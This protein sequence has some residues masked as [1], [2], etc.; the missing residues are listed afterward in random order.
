MVSF[1]VKIP[2]LPESVA[3]ATVIEWH[4]NLGDPVAAGENLV[5]IETDKVVLEVPAPVDGYLQRILVEP[6]TVVG[7]GDVVG[8]LHDQA[9][10][11]TEP[12]TTDPEQTT[13]ALAASAERAETSPTAPMQQPSNRAITPSARRLIKN[14]ALDPNRIPSQ[15]KARRLVKDDV[16]AYLAEHGQAVTAAQT[17]QETAPIDAANHHE[18]T[19]TPPTAATSPSDTK[20][21]ERRVPIT[22]LRARVAERLLAVTQQ[23]AMLTTFND[24]DMSSVIRLRQTHRERFEQRHGVRLGIMSFFAKATATALKRFPILNAALEEDHIVYHDFYDIGIAVSSSRGLVVPVVRHVDQLS[25]AEIEQQICDFAQ[26]AEAGQLSIDELAQGTFTITNG[27]V[28]GSL[29]STPII[30]P[31][32]TAILGMHRIEDRP[33]AVNGEV[34]IRPMMYLAL[35]YDHRLVDGRDAVRFLVDIKALIEEPARLLLDI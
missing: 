8:L 27:G 34:A 5:D 9:E 12:A 26:R 19:P 31:P 3:E 23:T 32:Q 4:K 30:N 6:G 11:A 25:M 28:F 22:P 14:H 2:P 20:R 1:E 21:P 24:V 33:I 7:A 15:T 18:F 35:S 17:S 13:P 10:A 29:L 16:T